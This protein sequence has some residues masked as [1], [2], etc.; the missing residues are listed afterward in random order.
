[1]MRRAMAVCIQEVSGFNLGLGSP[2]LTDVFRG[3]HQS[4]KA[5]TGMII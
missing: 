5:N 2:K 1:M 4:L 3:I